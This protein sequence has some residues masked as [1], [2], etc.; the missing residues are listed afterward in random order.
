MLRSFFIGILALV[1]WA[2]S[3]VKNAS[4]TSAHLTQKDQDTTEYDIVIIDPGFDQWYMANFS[5]AQD[6]T[7]D[8]YRTRN[9]VAVGNWNDYYRMGKHGNVIDSYIDYRPD[10]DYGI[11]VNRKLYWYFRYI[12]N[13][14]RIYLF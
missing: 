9:I 7:N 4:K 5:P 8:Y 3:P 2:C 10:V 6:R 13:K 14:Y 11:E 1:I 12:K